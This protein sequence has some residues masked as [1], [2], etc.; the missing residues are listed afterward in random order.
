MKGFVLIAM[1]FCHIFDD[2]KIQAG[3]LNN[4]KQKSW[5][6]ENAPAP[7]YK[8]DYLM[9]LTA[10]SLSWAFMIQLP[11]ALYYHFDVPNLFFFWFVL[12]AIIH[13]VVDDLKANRHLIN[14]ITDQSIHYFQVVGTWAALIALL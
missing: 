1:I 2:F 10:H 13:G 8:K 6:E 4:L 14:L 5:W 3:V 12:N 11:V 9:A 7:V